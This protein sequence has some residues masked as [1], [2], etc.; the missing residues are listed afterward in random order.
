MLVLKPWCPVAD[1]ATRSVSSFF[2]SR[3]PRKG[4]SFST[5]EGE[6]PPAMRACI[7]SISSLVEGFLRSMSN[8]RIQ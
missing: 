1:W 5:Y 7:Q 2:F 3:V 4:S 8:W 6:M